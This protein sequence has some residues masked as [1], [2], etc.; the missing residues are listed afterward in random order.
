M[1]TVV[2]IGL[3]LACS[4]L[5]ACSAII[6]PDVTRLGGD[7]GGTDSGSTMR[8]AGMDPD[9]A[10]RMCPASCDD[11]IA[12]TDDGCVDFACVSEPDDSAC[13]DGERCSPVLGCVDEMC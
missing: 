9:D 6:E 4:A 1:T 3:A 12:C 2:R 10:G 5:A 8:D 7:A 11:E 13:G